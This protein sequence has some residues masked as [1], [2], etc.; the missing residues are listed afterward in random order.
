M[1]KTQ[2]VYLFLYLYHFIIIVIVFIFFLFLCLYLGFLKI[3]R[4]FYVI[5]KPEAEGAARHVCRTAGCGNLNLILTVIA[6]LTS[7]VPEKPLVWSPRSPCFLEE[8][9]VA[10]RYESNPFRIALN[11]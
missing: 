2:Q 6:R 9:R 5:A 10:E 1:L 11:E 4:V 8:G 7:G 3:D